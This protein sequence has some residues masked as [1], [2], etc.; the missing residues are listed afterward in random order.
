MKTTFTALVAAAVM[1]G[2]GCAS[3]VQFV[4][5]DDSYT[6]R[7]K[8][9]DAE[10]IFRT[11]RIQRPHRVVGVITAT[12]GRDTRRPELDA[13]LIRKAR[14]VGADGV[15][16]VEYDVDREAYVDTHHAVVGRGPWK[17]RVVGRSRRV[18]VEKTASGIAVVFE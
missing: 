14:E 9:A 2:A 11:G 18:E 15:M 10:I 6:A 3:N 7:A 13:L 16:L 17:R 1:L 5:T 8:P 4:Q 12:L